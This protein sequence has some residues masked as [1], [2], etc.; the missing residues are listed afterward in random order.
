MPFL[1]DNKEC[2]E[3]QYSIMSDNSL[4]ITNTRLCD[5]GVYLVT[6]RNSGIVSVDETVRVTV[7]DPQ[8]PERELSVN[9]AIVTMHC[10][11]SLIEQKL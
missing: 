10:V 8:P 2:S 1:A 6:A 3:P 5:E 11:M 7:V 9:V 4:L